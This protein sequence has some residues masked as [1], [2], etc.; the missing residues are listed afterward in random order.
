MTGNHLY[1]GDNLEIL[2]NHIP[3]ASADLIYVDPPFNSSLSYSELFKNENGREN[4]A[5]IQAFE[6]TWHW[7]RDAEATYSYLIKR[8]TDNISRTVAAMRNFIGTNQ[9]MAYL[10]MMTV[11]L[12]E[13]RRV[14]KQTGS[15]YLHC[16]PTTSHYLKVILD[17]IFGAENFR[18]D[19]T[20]RRRST[21]NNV[22]LNV[23]AVTDTILYYVRS[24]K[25]IFNTQYVPYSDSYIK[26]FFR[27]VDARGRRYAV[28]SLTN[29]SVRPNLMY[30]YKGYPPPP[31]GW[32]CTR[33]KMQEYDRQGRLEFPSNPDGHIR[34]RYYLDDMP[35]TPVTNLWDDL[36]AVAEQYS[37]RLDYPTQKPLALLERI[38]SISSNPGGVVLDPFCGCGTSIAAAQKLGRQWIGIDVNSL[39]IAVMKYRL[40]DMYPG[41]TYRIEGEPH[42]MDGAHDLANRDR[43][44][45]QWWA[46]S[47]I[48]AQPLGGRVGSLTG[49]TSSDQGISGVIPFVDE[50]S[51]ES[52]YVL[53]QAKP[54]RVKSGDIRDL[55][56]KVE[57]EKAAIGVFITLEGPS[58]DMLTEA[59]T[60][61]Y[62]RSVGWN[63]NFFRL[64]IL[65]IADLLKGHAGVDIPPQPQPL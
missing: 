49:K 47:L 20:W 5:Q 58:H 29:P 44:Q 34:L 6:D 28:N 65:T 53:V 35:G 60:A 59:A 16:D 42:D 22:T 41:I 15:L 54:D 19:I 36:P 55:V 8:T 13:L 48:R 40:E 12:I 7:H 10:V 2:R 64:Q 46:L 43:Y 38:I 56:G 33:E 61:G 1:Y 27:Y 26:E 24:E 37:E 51:G 17:T 63:K 45:F 18:S 21:P 11:R 23:E 14:L 57:R 9:M 25:A 4:D 31:T 50:A 30:E 32:I 39:A 52:K 3:T 62:Y